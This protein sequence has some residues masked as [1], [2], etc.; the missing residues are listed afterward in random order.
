MSTVNVDRFST[1]KWFPF[2]EFLLMMMRSDLKGPGGEIGART[3]IANT[4]KRNAG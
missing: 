4:A 2:S 1:N 3:E